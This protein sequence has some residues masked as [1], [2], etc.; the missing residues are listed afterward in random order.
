[1]IFGTFN[2]VF[3]QFLEKNNAKGA[4]TFIV[5]SR[6][7]PNDPAGTPHKFPGNAMDFS[8]RYNGDYA[9][10]SWYN[11]LFA[12]LLNEWRFRAGID[13]TPK[14]TAPGKRGNVHI[15]VDMGLT[16]P[17]G[18]ALPYFFKEE[19]GKFVK[20]VKTLGDIS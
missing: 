9:G 5:T 17:E 16:R 4:L 15:H 1:M 13:N 2:D 10:I 14:P 6:D 19:D 12:F 20:E 7:R 8:L 18:Q 11:S 3:E